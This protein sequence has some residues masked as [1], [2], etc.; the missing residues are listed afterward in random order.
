MG[1]R[2]PR[3]YTLLGRY[4]WFVPGVP[5]LFI[6]LAFFALGVLLGNL[7]EILCLMLG[8][9]EFALEYGTLISYPF[10]FLPAMMD[11]SVKSSRGR[12]N[13]TGVLMD[14]G[15]FGKPGGL[16]CALLAA[17][18]TISLA[19]V[20]D[21]INSFLP[22]M[23]EW[24]EQ[25]LGGLTGGPLWISLL[26]V[27]VFAPFFEEWLCRGTVLRGLLANGVKPVWSIVISALFFGL[28]HLNPWQ[29][30]PAFLL[31]CLFG[32]VYYKTGSLKLTMLMH[33]VNNSLAVAA[34]YIPGLEEAESWMDVFPGAQYW[35]IC[36]ACALLTILIVRVFS[37]IPQEQPE[38]NL[39]RVPSLF[40]E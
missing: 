26:C 12:F 19:F 35:T 32:Y 21:G 39:T 37:R 25:A 29:A 31:G 38:G 2:K 11:S 28:I 40:D 27:S 36:A 30:I 4:S 1:R 6:I 18:G 34:G 9:Q 22:A 5:Q 10:M 17:L 7:V 13:R 33:C 16:G 8:G 3:N 24:L 23:P 14:G 15:V 20:A